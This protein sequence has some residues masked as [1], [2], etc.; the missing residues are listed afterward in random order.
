MS[1]QIK[2]NKPREMTD[3]ELAELMKKISQVH[4]ENGWKA[5]LE[6]EKLQ[7]L[8]AIDRRTKRMQSRH[9]R[10]VKLLID[11]SEDELT[12]LMSQA[13]EGYDESNSK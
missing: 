10:P 8:E 6:R 1:K 9:E 3:A 12:E 4:L 7:T 5:R 11:L 2:G 13:V